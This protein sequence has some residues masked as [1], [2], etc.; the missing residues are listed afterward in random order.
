M[1]VLADYVK[2]ISMIIYFISYLH[3]YRYVL[4]GAGNLISKEGYNECDNVRS[5]QYHILVLLIQAT[6]YTFHH[7]FPWHH[8][9]Y[10]KKI[11]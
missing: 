10:S 7:T 1:L 4:R 11:I 3:I 2:I 9:F 8:C 6:L 5:R